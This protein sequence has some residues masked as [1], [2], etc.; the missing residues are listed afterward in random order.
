MSI[1]SRDEI[2]QSFGN[3]TP[4]M[5]EKAMIGVWLPKEVKKKYSE[6]QKQSQ[7]ELS[8]TIRDVVISSVEEC[9]KTYLSLV[10]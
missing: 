5:E 4:S 9:Y 6:L 3:K 10:K 1:K 8:K 7:L 2:I